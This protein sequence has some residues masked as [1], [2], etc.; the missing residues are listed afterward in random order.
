MHRRWLNT[1]VPTVGAAVLGNAFIGREALSWFTGLRRPAM[2]LPMWG[3]YLVG[4]LSYPLM[5]V[6][7]Y[8]AARQNDLR[9][10]RL[11]VAVLAAGELWNAFLFGGR[12]TRNGF[13]G[14]LAFTLPLGLLQLSVAHDPVSRT[15]LAPYT[16]WVIGYDIPWTYQLWRLN[17]DGQGYI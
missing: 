8:R 2:Q 9:S 12:N 14:I 3:F 16:A 13:L 10:Y 15:F 17:P 4:S 1:L 7:V 11:A 5:G 6:V